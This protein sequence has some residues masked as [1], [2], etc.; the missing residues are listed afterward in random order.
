MP[1]WI[2]DA[3]NPLFQLGSIHRSLFI[4]KRTSNITS[5]VEVT[6]HS[7]AQVD[8][9]HCW[10]ASGI[11]KDPAFPYS[12]PG[13]PSSL[14][15]PIQPN[16]GASQLYLQTAHPWNQPLLVTPSTLVQAVTIPCLDIATPPSWPLCSPPSILLQQ[17]EEMQ[18]CKTDQVAS[19]LQTHH[20]LLLCFGIRP[21]HLSSLLPA[22]RHLLSSSVHALHRCTAC[23]CHRAFALA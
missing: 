3:W 20:G 23:A 6:K 4:F 22:V 10:A 2:G 13:P 7:G 21:K 8:A 5:L 17:T 18:N 1:S 11:E 14:F 19:L 12:Y 16:G 15:F 9:K